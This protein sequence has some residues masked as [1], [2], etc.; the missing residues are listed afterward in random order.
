MFFWKKKKESSSSSAGWS[1]R[2]KELLLLLAGLAL[3]LAAIFLA[4]QRI[5]AAEREVHQKISPVEIVVPSVSIRAGEVFTEQNLAKKSVPA[6]GTGS[7][8]VPAAEFELLLGA[9]AKGTL[10][11]GEPILWTDV[12]EPFDPEKFSQ[13]I[14]AG[15]RAFTLEVN[16]SSS[17]AGL[18]RPGDVVDLLCE[19]E[20]GRTPQAWIRA[21]PV[22]SVDRHFAKTPSREESRDISTVTVSVSPEEGRLLAAASRD[23]RIL[24]FLRNP[25]EPSKS[26]TAPTPRKNPAAG[27]IEIWKAGM[28]ESQTTST[29]GEPG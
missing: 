28:Q 6:T 19:G 18:I 3:T 23:G 17:F 21:I 24:W 27:K 5:T 11:A 26:A 10:A 25:T 7:R 2:S 29:I 4:R 22:I 14:P 20:A 12:E 15:R 16:T 13:T 1:K 8:N 9:H